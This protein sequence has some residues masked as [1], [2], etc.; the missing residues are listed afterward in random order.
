MSTKHILTPIE[1]NWASSLE[2]MLFEEDLP[3]CCEFSQLMI[4]QFALMYNGDLDKSLKRAKGYAAAYETYKFDTATDED[5]IEWALN[6]MPQTL[7]CS[8]ND[9][10][11]HP[12]CVYDVEYF[13]V[14]N[15]IQNSNDLLYFLK[16]TAL[17]V[18]LCCVDLDEIR[19][20]TVII[21]Q[22][23]NLSMGCVSLELERH[24]V[25]LLQDGYP[26][27]LK[28]VCLVDTPFLINVVL[29]MFRV[30][31]SK[32]MS[33]RIIL[34]DSSMLLDTDV[35]TVVDSDA[36]VDVDSS[37][38]TTDAIHGTDIDNLNH[39]SQ[40]RSQNMV[41]GTVKFNNISELPQCL[42]GTYSKTMREFLME[43]LLRRRES[44]QSVIF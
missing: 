1:A 38:T 3:S 6:H 14:N 27:K 17:C 13:I 15:I 36:T 9:K 4:A 37:T 25:F 21:Q 35:D 7:C 26:V 31:L 11:G 23:R 34:V 22:C 20:G 12:T 18:E 29:R 40:R 43:K 19:A 16:Y 32:K 8:A 41:K 10:A 30:F 2:Q 24:H 33:E 42:G 39:E 44:E 28:A 5:A